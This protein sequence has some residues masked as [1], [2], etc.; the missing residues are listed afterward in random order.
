[1]RNGTVCLPMRAHPF[2]T[3][4]VPRQINQLPADAGRREPHERL[5]GI[6][7]DVGQ[8][9]VQSQRNVLPQV[10]GFFQSP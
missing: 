5:D 3:E 4:V 9:L 8:G 1:M 6:G 10:G 7:P 2:G